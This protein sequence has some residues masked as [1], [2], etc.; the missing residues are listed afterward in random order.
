MSATYAPYRD[1]RVP[2]LKCVGEI[3]LVYEAL[4]AARGLPRTVM[5]PGDQ[6]SSLGPMNG[7]GNTG[8]TDELSKKCVALGWRVPDRYSGGR[9]LHA[10][11]LPSTLTGPSR[12][13][14]ASTH[15][16]RR[17]RGKVPA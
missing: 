17:R 15:F 5:E 16:L 14:A 11:S 3:A 13:S 7:L 12:P 6:P 1:P 4:L 2:V 8:H 10:Y 9:P